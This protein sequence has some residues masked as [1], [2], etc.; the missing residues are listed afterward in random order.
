LKSWTDTGK[1]VHDASHVQDLLPGSSLPDS[2]EKV[3]GES[4]AV[5][6]QKDKA[7]IGVFD[8][9]CMGMYN[10]V[11]DD[12]LMNPLGIY[13]ERLTQSALWADMLIVPNDEADAVGAWLEEKGLIFKLGTDEKTESTTAQL[14]WQYKM[15][16]AALRIGDDYG[17]DAMGSSINKV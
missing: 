14:K 3:L 4:L 15:Y 7:V 1:I 12:E 9:G 8:E 11:T 13:K 6:L 2:P 10:A 5:Q 17:L 16:I